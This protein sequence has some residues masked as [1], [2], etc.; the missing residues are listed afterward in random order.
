VSPVGLVQPVRPPATSCQFPVES[1][2]VRS[3]A[4]ATL[5]TASGSGTRSGSAARACSVRTASDGTTSTASSPIGGSNRC[6]RGPSQTTKPP[7]SAAD[8]LS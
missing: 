3:D 7:A 4:Q 2:S 6:E 1:P 8:T 5:N